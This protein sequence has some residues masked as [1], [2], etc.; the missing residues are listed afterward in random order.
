MMS[1]SEDLSSNAWTVV[2]ERASLAAARAIVERLDAAGIAARILTKG[3]SLTAATQRKPLQVAT[4]RDDSDRARLLLGRDAFS[5]DADAVD[6]HDPGEALEDRLIPAWP[7]CERCGSPRQAECPTCGETGVRFTLSRLVLATESPRA[8]RR[9]QRESNEGTSAGDEQM[10]CPV[11]DEVFPP[12]YFRRCGVCG[13]D[14]ADG[15]QVQPVVEAE[16]EHISWGSALAVVSLAAALW[17]IAW[18][19]P[20]LAM[21]TLL[22]ASIIWLARLL[23]RDA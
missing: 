2:A 16:L 15:L 1:S 19:S 20:A 21:A 22:I 18:L 3:G 8:T 12:R 9:E 7:R 13:H 4:R 5:R 6:E 11:C 17:A 23:G 10:V 14:H